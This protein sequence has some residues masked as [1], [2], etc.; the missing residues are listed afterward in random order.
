MEKFVW[1][2][3]ILD[4]RIDEYIERHDKIWPKMKEAL[5]QAG[6]CNYSIWL[7][8]DEI[9]GY[10]EC[11]KGVKYAREFQDNSP[12]VKEWDEYMKDILVTEKDPSTG[13]T[14]KFKQAFYLE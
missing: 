1:K 7:N 12:V 4:N 13:E 11:E 6:I 2:G 10:Y 9:F 5:K 3:K 14:V 8:G